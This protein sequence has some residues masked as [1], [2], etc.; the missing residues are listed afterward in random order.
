MTLVW[1]NVTFTVWHH[2]I[3]R[4]PRKPVEKNIAYA[5]C[6]GREVVNM[7]SGIDRETSKMIAFGTEGD[8]RNCLRESSSSAV[9]AK[10]AEIESKY[11]AGGDATLTFDGET[12]THML[13]DD[14]ACIGDIHPLKSGATTYWVCE[15]RMVFREEYS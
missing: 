11:Q 12:H 15:V 1:N 2:V 13:L 7:G 3:E 8:K 6:R 10:I 4:R 5:N 14:F 9:A